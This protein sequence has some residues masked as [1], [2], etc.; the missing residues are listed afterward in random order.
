MCIYLPTYIY[1]DAIYFNIIFYIISHPAH[2]KK[3][4]LQYPIMIGTQ[5]PRQPQYFVALSAVE[6]DL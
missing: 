5:Y 1:I 6:N 2:R 3:E 4:T